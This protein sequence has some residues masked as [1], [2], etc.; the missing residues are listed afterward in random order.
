MAK[1]HA[2]VKNHTDLLSCYR[3]NYVTNL[4]LQNKW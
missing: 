3:R 1:K 2:H 4:F